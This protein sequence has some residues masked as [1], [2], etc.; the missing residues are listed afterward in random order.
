MHPTTT[1][2]YWIHREETSRLVSAIKQVVKVDCRKP[3]GTRFK[4]DKYPVSIERTQQACTFSED[5]LIHKIIE[6]KF[7][8]LVSRA[9]VAVCRTSILYARLVWR[10]VGMVCL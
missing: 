2:F 8:R 10:M 7:N 5:D 9:V 1:C 3:N 4:N 6:K